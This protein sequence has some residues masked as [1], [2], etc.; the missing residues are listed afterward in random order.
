[1]TPSEM[2][3]SILDTLLEANPL[4]ITEYEMRDR[5]LRGCPLSHHP[6][7]FAAIKELKAFGIVKER[8]DV[9]ESGYLFELEG[10]TDDE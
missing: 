7:Y 9:N 6:I 2:K 5:M 3:R 1:M 8:F 4:A 10:N